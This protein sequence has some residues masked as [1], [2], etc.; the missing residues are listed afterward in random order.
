[1]ENHRVSPMR[2]LRYSDPN[3]D[4][5]E[6]MSYIIDTDQ[7][8]INRSSPGAFLIISFILMAGC[9]LPAS[10]QDDR[11]G[12]DRMSREIVTPVW[13]G[14]EQHPL[15]AM[16]YRRI[17]RPL[18]GLVL[19]GGGARGIA[20]VGVIEVLEQHG[21]PIDFLVG[22][23]MGSLIGGLYAGG[24]TTDA[25][26]ALVDTTDW[27]TILSL[28]TDADRRDQFI[29]Q[30]LSKR[31][32]IFTLRFDGIEPVIPASVTPAQRLSSFINEL[33]IQSIYHPLDSFDDLRVP[34]RAVS[35]DLIS[36]KRILFDRGDL[37]QAIRSSV[38]IPLVFAPVRHDSMMLVDGGL[39]A[40]IPVD[41]AR[42]YGCDIVIAVNTTSGLRPPEAMNAPWEIA[43]QIITI[44]Q[45][46]WNHDQLQLADV[47]ITPPIDR[48]IGT[49]FD[50][51][52]YFVEQGRITTEKAVPEI[53][54]LI[55]RYNRRIIE[56][57]DEAYPNPNFTFTGVEPSEEFFYIQEVLNSQDTLQKS[58][59]IDVLN[60]IYDSGY[61]RDVYATIDR[62]NDLTAVN[63]HLT[64]NPVL[65]EVTISGNNLI[66]ID[67]L[68]SGFIPLQ[69][70]SLN[71]RFTR[72]ALESILSMYRAE[73]YSL[74][75]ITSNV[76]NEDTGILDIRIDE[77]IIGGVS[78]EGNRKTK[79]YVIRREFTLSGGDVFTVSRAM[80]GIRNING[81]G[82]FNQVLL[83]VVRRDGLPHVVIV[84][85]ERYSELLRLSLMVD[86]TYHFQ[87]VVEV[88]N[89]NFFG[90]AIEAG[91]GFGGGTRNRILWGELITHRIF[92]TYLSLGLHGYYSFQD[93][94][95]YGDVPDSPASRWRRELIG[96]YRQFGTGGKITLGAQFERFGNVAA[97]VRMENQRLRNREGTAISPAG[98]FIVANRF[99][100]TFDTYDRYPF[101]SDGIGLS[102]FYEIASS[103]VGSDVSY[104]KFFI[105]YETY[106]TYGRLHTFRPK[107]VF[108][109]G[110][111]TMPLTEFFTLGGM[112]SFYGMRRNEYRGRQ[113]FT[114]NF[115]YRLR[116][117]F[118]ILVDTYLHA[119][120]DL[121]AAWQTA[122]D[123]RLGDLRHGL[124]I[125]I[126]F[127]TGIFGPLEFGLGRAYLSRGD[128]VDGVVPAGVTHTYF[129]I[130]I[131]LF[132]E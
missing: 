110:D 4:C 32:G 108:G 30:K 47:V 60:R 115:E 106:S 25:M 59:L 15:D 11:G 74:A 126:G 54:S 2:L 91:I 37:V 124:G 23:S 73:G 43:D 44:M 71:H 22:T 67:S 9:L 76:F 52:G 130:G 129:N 24:Y 38:S 39:V 131:P 48:Y 31:R 66:P 96:E 101:P 97:E 77:G 58:E 42:E 116:L 26:M 127:D 114:A 87:P 10:A 53:H 89:E 85:D 81:T 95:V 119:R 14:M 33:V 46:R 17:K 51:I 1:M 20:Q 90:N 98:T 78:I 63:I 132:E 8:K 105:R 27:S 128:I 12:T 18:I 6:H 68:L 88:R 99:S 34:F 104:T 111:D 72:S 40:N 107:L 83:N 50:H 80:Q 117:P 5:I 92:N 16:P 45:Q 62:A 13:S 122:Q 61:Y 21:I 93:F 70:A 82:L 125:G 28:R 94:R 103:F 36:G 84:V 35:T 113:I 49:D 100:A 29:G 69:N 55:D 65:R 109:F 102:A 120:Y 79:I 123:I 112:D 86:E 57:Y 64:P 75:R 121:G 3:T 7:V 41:V 118:K 19:S 56:D